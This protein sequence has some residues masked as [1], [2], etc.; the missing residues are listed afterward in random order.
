[1]VQIFIK[2]SLNPESK[3]LFLIEL[4]GMFESN[5]TSLNNLK[6]GELDLSDTNKPKIRVG[7]QQLIGVRTKLKE[8]FALIMN[9]SKGELMDRDTNNLTYGL[10]CI[11]R[12]KLLFETRPGLIINKLD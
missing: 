7:N 9:Q 8:P 12:E 1:M 4:Q 3:E 10:K 6:V 5:Q 11:I 2:N